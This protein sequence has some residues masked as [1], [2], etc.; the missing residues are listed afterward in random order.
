ML[1]D[2][3]WVNVYVVCHFKTL[4]ISQHILVE[5][6][7]NFSMSLQKLLQYSSFKQ[8]MVENFYFIGLSYGW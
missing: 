7:N 1:C 4:L 3:D 6:V 8:N 5:Q 2:R